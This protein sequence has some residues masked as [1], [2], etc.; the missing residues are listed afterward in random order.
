MMWC[1]ALDLQEAVAETISKVMLAA[2]CSAAGDSFAQIRWIEIASLVPKHY[3][4]TQ[5]DLPIHQLTLVNQ[6]VTASTET[7]SE[8]VT[9][10]AG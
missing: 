8:T 1:T 5:R 9:E 2:K 10:L 4:S 6:K 3:A 7:V